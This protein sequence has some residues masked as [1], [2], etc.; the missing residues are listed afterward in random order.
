MTDTIADAPNAV[1]AVPPQ[2]DLSKDIERSI[3][4]RADER[5]R[6]SHLVDDCYRCNWW[7]QDTTTPHL[8]WLPTGTIRKS[9][10]R[11]RRIGP[12]A[13]CVSRG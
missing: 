8:F 9:G 1:S 10:L 2:A 5:V 3:E 4:R 13:A 6:V 12:A 7:V 11:P